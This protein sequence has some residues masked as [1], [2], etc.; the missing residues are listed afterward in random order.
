ME[1]RVAEHHVEHRRKVFDKPLIALTAAERSDMS[2]NKD[3]STGRI[4]SEVLPLVYDWTSIPADLTTVKEGGLIKRTLLPLK[5]VVTGIQDEEVKYLKSRETDIVAFGKHAQNFAAGL[6]LNVAKLTYPSRWNITDERNKAWKIISELHF[7]RGLPFFETEDD[8]SKAV[9][10]ALLIRCPESGKS[11][12]RC[13]G[14]NTLGPKGRSDVCRKRAQTLGSQSLSAMLLEPPKTDQSAAANE[15]QPWV[16]PDY[17]N[18]NAIASRQWESKVLNVLRR[19]KGI[20]KGR[21][22]NCPILRKTGSHK[23][24]MRKSPLP[25]PLL[26]VM[27]KLLHSEQIAQNVPSEQPLLPM[28]KELRRGYS[29]SRVPRVDAQPTGSLKHVQQHSQH[30]SLLQACGSIT[31]EQ[32]NIVHF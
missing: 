16:N 6:G 15:Q 12:R 10:A 29:D 1:D 20:L 7:N 28:H 18:P 5:Q 26:S 2:D 8:F 4:F 27:Q 17:C 13:R 31:E 23:Q 21:S 25:Q 30:V 32:P 14:Q 3:T 24:K 9:K 11:L 22:G 19:H